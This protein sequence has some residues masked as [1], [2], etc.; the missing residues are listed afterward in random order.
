MLLK[1][2]FIETVIGFLWREYS[3][4]LSI[5]ALVFLSVFLMPSGIQAVDSPSHFESGIIINT[6]DTLTKGQEQWKRGELDKALLTLK[7]AVKLDPFNKQIAKVFKSMQLQKKRIDGLLE[8]ASDLIEKNNYQDAK[9]SLHKA[10]FINDKYFGYQKV[11]QKLIG[12]QKKSK[13]EKSIDQVINKTK[14]SD[15]KRMASFIASSKKFQ[16]IAANNYADALLA[17]SRD[18]GMEKLHT[19][20]KII[21]DVKICQIGWKLF[22]DSAIRIYNKELDKYP[23]VTYYNP[24][25]DTY[26]ITVWA[27]DNERYKIVD[28][29]FLMGDFVRGSS[30][31]FDNTPFWLREKKRSLANLGV[32][33]ALSILAFEEVFEKTTVENWRKKLKI[34]NNTSALQEFNYLNISIS[35]NGHLINVGNFLNIKDDE[36][37]LQECRDKTR[38]ILK[39]L[40]N[41]NIDAI[42]NTANETPLN[43]AKA[44]RSVSPKWI[45]NLTVNVALNDIYECLVLL[46][47]RKKTNVSMSFLL[48]DNPIKNQLQIKRID[49]ID[50]QQFYDAIKAYQEKKLKGVLL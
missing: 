3:K 36:P 50:Y 33:T 4:Q 47:P 22:F 5:Y 30:K 24:F 23:L 43:T 35:L 32:S 25:S 44:L 13:E 26:L 14:E 28:A 6:K 2:S 29:E 31:E 17:L 49:L 1:K 15:L 12:T 9:K 16:E 45:K 39:A 34:L 37:L 40:K 46:T 27:Q 20:D 41:G 11:F 48:K 21:W 7:E 42:L 38:D 19:M 8:K 10:S 18:K